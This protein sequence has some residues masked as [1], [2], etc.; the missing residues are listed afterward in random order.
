MEKDRQDDSDNSVTKE[1]N[2]YSKKEEI[3][4]YTRNEGSVDTKSSNWFNKI[5][6]S[7]IKRISI[8]IIS[9]LLIG[10]M[11]G[12]IMIKMITNIDVSVDQKAEGIQAS[13][14]DNANENEANSNSTGIE[15]LEAYVLQVGV[16]SEVSNA[17]EWSE[18]FNNAGIQTVTW[19]KEGSL[20]LLAGVSSIEEQAKVSAEKIKESEFDVFV[21]EWKT[22]EVN[23]NVSSEE[24]QWI[25]SFIQIW[26]ETLGSITKKELYMAGDWDKLTNQYPEESSAIKEIVGIIK[27]HAIEDLP[28]MDEQ[29][30]EYVLLDIWKHYETIFN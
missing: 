7:N 8:S 3:E 25:I 14:N 10:S 20:F 28:N 18:K 5:N 26:E 4:P 1:E 17:E 24:Q 9:A 29:Q 21:K 30:K 2:T 23:N 16:F 15:S 19:E 11:L 22:T 6:T 13:V 12:F 27:E